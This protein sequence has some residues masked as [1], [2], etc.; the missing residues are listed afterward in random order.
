MMI[1]SYKQTMMIIE[2][3]VKNRKKSK[4]KARKN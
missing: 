2:T 4:N 3:E 1:K